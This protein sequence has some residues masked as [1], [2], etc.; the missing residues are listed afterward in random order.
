MAELTNELFPQ[1]E[2]FERGWLALDHGHQM[3]WQLSGNPAA[4]PVIWI[5]GGPGS[6]ATPLHRRL[7]DPGRFLIIQHDQRGCGA[8]EPQGSIEANTAAILVA[9]IERLR[10][11]LGV[12]R[13]SVAGGSWGATLALLYA[14][15][16]PDAVK[17]LMLRSPFL[18]TA[19][20]ING[21]LGSPRSSCLAS[22]E[23]LQ[24]ECIGLGGSTILDTSYQVFCLENDVAAQI[25]LA[26]AWVQYEA[27]MDAYPVPVAPLSRFN[28]RALRARYRVHVHYLKHQCFVEQPILTHPEA[29]DGKAVTLVHGDQDALCPFGNSLAI[30]RAVPHAHLRRVAGAGHNMVEP[31]MLSALVREIQAWN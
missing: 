22:W 1:L 17:R 25:Q 10:L 7:F 16:Y 21:F 9:D 20:E 24:H 11:A 27:A 30:A 26:R 12:S 29:F 3:H 6:S 19:A 23:R 2:P 5:H 13:W 31:S 18:A 14:Q 28:D 8:S 15:A 4:E